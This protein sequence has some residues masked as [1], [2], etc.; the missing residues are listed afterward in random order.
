VGVEIQT[1]TRLT[2][3]DKAIYRMV[4]RRASCEVQTWNEQSALQLHVQVAVGV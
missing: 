1:V 4:T 2:M 3:M